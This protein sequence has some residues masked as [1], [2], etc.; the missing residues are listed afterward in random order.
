MKQETTMKTIKVFIAS[1]EELRM[2]RLEFTD[3]IQHLNRIFKPRGFEIEPVKWEYLDASMGPLHKQEEYNQ[4]L[5]T[6]EICLALYWTKFGEYTESE[7][8]TAY[9]ELKAGRNPRK[10]YVY[11]KDTQDITP[12][13]QAFKDSFA[14]KYGH[15]FCR[16]ENVDTMRL[17][18]LLQFEDY[19]NHRHD[20]SLIKVRNSKVEVDEQPFAD[21]QQVPFCGKNPEYQQLLQ[22]IE[23]TQARVL[24]YPDEMEFRQELHDLQEKRELMEQSLLD[25]AK[26]I[27]KLSATI[28]SARL[29]EAIRLFEQGDNKGA[30]AVLNMADIKHDAQAN[31][32]RIDAAR[33]LEE[34]AREALEVN[35]EEYQLKID[36]IKSS[37]AAGWVQEIIDI[38]EEAVGVAR[39]RISQEKFVGLLFKYANFLRENKQY[40]LIGNLY[41]EC[42][43]ICRQL[44]SENEDAYLPYVSDTLNNLA[45]LHANLRHFAGAECEFVEALDIYRQLASKNEDT[46]LPY[47]ADTLNNLAVL[48]WNLH[49]F[50]EAEGEYVE[51]LALCRQLAAKGADVNLS[52]VANTL[53][54][55]ALLHANLHRFDEAEC[56]YAEALEI[57]RQLSAKKPDAYLPEVADTL[58]NLAVLHADLHRFDEAEGEYVEALDIRRQLASKNADAYLPDVADTLNNLGALH[59]NL[60]R[61]DEAE[62]EFVEAL[63]IYRQL[64]AKNADAFLSTMAYMLNNL[65]ILHANLHRF[66]EAECEYAEALDIYRQLSAKNADAFLPYVAKILYNQ[67][68][69]HYNIHRFDEA[70]REYVEALGIFR[71]LSA[72]NADAFL[73]DVAVT[74]YNLGILY[75]SNIQYAQV[76]QCWTEALE[77]YQKLSQNVSIYDDKI[78]NLTAWLEKIKDK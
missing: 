61:F 27:T 29:A 38:Y 52:D 73:P 53:N 24:K 19:Q 37:M 6:C 32:A 56:E 10:L 3:M 12:E 18:F 31:A 78:E 64:S 58:N 77:I 43:T 51:T 23:K 2:E 14:T 42:L 11:F 16:F 47:V 41:D 34:S 30:N 20:R 5:K 68:G 26:R 50:D 46:Y 72:K 36:T 55:L 25:T 69:L 48:H 40:H 63:D 49:R 59:A 7:L 21:L 35:I 75:G 57:R 28:A 17:N 67:A 13:L 60:H 71:Q 66:D 15:F 39:N 76:R 44:A 1:S 74:L 70:E 22:D 54:N 4:E 9:E 8:N 33:E 62:G 65:G 45:I